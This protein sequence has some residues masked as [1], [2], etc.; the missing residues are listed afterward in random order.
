MPP[1]PFSW[2]MNCLRNINK[3]P[4]WKI[5]Y[6]AI[7]NWDIHHSFYNSDFQIHKWDNKFW[8]KLFN[9]QWLGFLLLAFSVSDS[10]I[11]VSPKNGALFWSSGKSKPNT[12]KMNYSFLLPLLLPSGH[13]K[14][15][16]F[17]LMWLHYNP[18]FCYYSHSPQILLKDLFFVRRQPQACCLVRRHPYKRCSFQHS[19]DIQWRGQDSRGEW[20]SLQAWRERHLMMFEFWAWISWGIAKASS[21]V[22]TSIK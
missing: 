12:A 10:T 22:W 5:L 3:F 4:K 1:L 2:R 6:K 11:H 14:C 13:G 7:P 9:R 19:D 20:Q 8:G 17:G 18:L 21:S 15:S 16:I